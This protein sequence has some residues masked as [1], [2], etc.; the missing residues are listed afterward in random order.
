VIFSLVLFQGLTLGASEERIDATNDWIHKSLFH[1]HMTEINFWSKALTLS[2]II[3]VTQNCLNSSQI[4]PDLFDWFAAVNSFV[5]K[6][7]AYMTVERSSNLCQIPLDTV[8][9]LFT[10]LDTFENAKKICQAFSGSMFVPKNVKHLNEVIEQVNH[11]NTLVARCRESFWIGLTKTGFDNVQNQNGQLVDFKPWGVGDPNGRE[12]QKC[13]KTVQVGMSP[14][15]VV[16]VFFPFS[17]IILS[18]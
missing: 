12:F 5:N 18:R 14:Y 6:P 16:T 15:F 10:E 17:Q 8:P 4:S 2:E 13:I 7:Y 3:D 1:G 9:V 11:G